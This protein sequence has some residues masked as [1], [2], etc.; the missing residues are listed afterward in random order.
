MERALL[1]AERGRGTTSPNPMVGAVIVAD[2]VVVGQGAHLRAGGPHAEVVALEA[3]GDRAR[4]ASLYCTLEPC[5]HTGKTGPCVER[6]VP[7]GISRV[8]AAMTDPNPRVS[9]AGFKYLAERQIEVGVGVHERAARSLVAPFVTWVTRHRPFVIAK[10]AVSADGFVG[11]AGPRTRLTG[12]AADRYLHRQR[13]EVDAIA[14]GAGTVLSDDPWLTARH[15][16]R[17]RPFVRV[18][19]DWRLRVRPEARVFSTLSD[20]PVIMAV[21][22]A[23]ADQ[24]PERVETLARRGIEIATFER[25]DVNEVLR[26]LAGKDVTSLLVE[27]GPQLHEAFFTAKLVDRVQR[28]ATPRVLGTGVWAAEGFGDG[29][30]REAARTKALGD[31]VLVEWDVHGTD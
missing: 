1:L 31:D 3:A 29:G 28:V 8:V 24:Q 12:A 10:A 22:R 30:L 26:W 2:G 18:V 16:W 20:G 21:S 11:R 9:G 27:G 6:I 13:A 7:A 25:R 14:V 23:A 4:G 15:V 17:G 5:S 19:F